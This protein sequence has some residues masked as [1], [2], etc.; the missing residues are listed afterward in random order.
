MKA[1]DYTLYL[2]GSGWVDVPGEPAKGRVGSLVGGSVGVVQGF[3]RSFRFACF[4]FAFVLLSSPFPKM[5]LLLLLLFSQL[6]IQDAFC[7]RCLFQMYGG[8]GGKQKIQVLVEPFSRR[9]LL[10]CHRYRT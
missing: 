4:F 9:K 3:A 10:I 2:M 5:L 6:P 1:N 8:G 7:C